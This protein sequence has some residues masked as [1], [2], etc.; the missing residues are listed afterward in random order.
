MAEVQILQPFDVGDV[1]EIR[2]KEA[3]AIDIVIG[4]RF[5]DD[6]EVGVLFP[7]ITFTY[8]VDRIDGSCA[9]V[10]LMVVVEGEGAFIVQNGIGFQRRSDVDQCI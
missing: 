7:I 8:F 6:N 2:K 1:A 3:F 9:L 4:E 5:V 10:F